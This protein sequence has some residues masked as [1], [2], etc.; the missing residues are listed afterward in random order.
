[1]KKYCLTGLVI[2]TPL[3]LT[4]LLVV[5]LV[6]LFTN[7]FV[8]IVRNFFSNIMPSYPILKS[9]HFLSL[10]SRVTILVILFF[11]IVLLGFLGRN[12][13]FKILLKWSNELLSKTPFIK[14]IYKTTRDIIKSLFP[15]SEK[16]KAFLRPIMVPFPSSAG[17]VVGFLS[18][19]IPKAV[20]E[21]TT[22]E[23][24]PVFVPTAPHPISG[25]FVLVPKEDVV[26]VDMDNEKAVK[27]T[28]SCG[29]IVPEENIDLDDLL[30]KQVNKKDIK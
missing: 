7:P 27:L 30:P 20:Q 6:D 1:M 22:Q 11:A 29:L 28:V 14:S 23:L 18:G 3:I 2:I 9:P 12:F 25:Y 16:K 24:Y 17:Y 8:D 21:K 5:F 26:E 13:L 4:V 15:T 10:L 19:E